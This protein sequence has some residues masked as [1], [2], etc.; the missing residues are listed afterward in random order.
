M[1]F[2]CG[3]FVLFGEAQKFFGACYSLHFGVGYSVLL[4]RH[5]VSILLW[6]KMCSL[7][8]HRVYFFVWDTM[9]SIVR[10]TFTFCY[11][12]YFSVWCGIQCNVF[13]AYSL[14]FLRHTVYFLVRHRVY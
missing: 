8:R 11:G 7:V 6:H 9:Y 12:I 5:T 2:W 13:A 4:L 10:H 1:H 3:I 14:L